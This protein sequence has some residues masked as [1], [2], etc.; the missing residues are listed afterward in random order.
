MPLPLPAPARKI[1][2]R[3]RLAV[4]TE[5]AAFWRSRPVQVDQVLYE[6]FAGNGV[7]C[8]PEAI[9]R[10]LLDHPDYS[11][12]KHVWAISDPASIARFEAEFARH[13]RVSHVRR[14]SRAYVA[15]LATSGYLVNNATFPPS[16]GKRQIGRA[17]V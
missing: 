8:N 7:G 1:A 5:H 14:G 16:F 6:S 9:F 15:A 12:L 11:H 10:H 4:T 3:A 2:Q 13:P 17:H